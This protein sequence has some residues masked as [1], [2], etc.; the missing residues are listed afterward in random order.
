LMT[1]KKRGHSASFSEAAVSGRSG[2][3][4]RFCNT[5]VLR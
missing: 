4:L 5:A 1:G 3:T 2:A